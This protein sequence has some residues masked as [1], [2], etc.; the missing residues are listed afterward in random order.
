MYK[1]T[2]P[3]NQLDE[4]ETLNK[5][6]TCGLIASKTINEIVNKTVPGI[7]VK[8]LIVIGNSFVN[9]EMSKI[10]SDI[11][12]KGIAFPINISINSVAGNN[13]ITDI[14]IN[15]D[16][17]VKIDLSVH[18]D[19]YISSICFTTL[20]KS[21][22]YTVDDKKSK[23]LK[24]A[25]ECSREIFNHMKSG[26]TNKNIVNIMEKYTEKY[27]CNLPLTN[28]LV[29]ESPGLFSRQI[30]QYVLDG[31][32]DKCE[33]D[34][35]HKFI[36]CKDNPLYSFTLRETEF[37]EGEVYIIDIMMCSGTGKLVEN[38]TTTNIYRRDHEN[39]QML[40]LNTSKQVLNIFGLNTFPI[41]LDNIDSRTKLGLKECIEKRLV[42][43]Y[44][45][46]SEKEGEFIAR[47]KFT[48][49][50]TNDKP[51]LI[52]GRPAETELAKLK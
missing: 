2:S 49:L 16:D 10:Y 18:I 28:V 5:Y 17:L 3:I 30:S 14:I 11:K 19:G 31:Y 8:E 43:P 21:G 13:P 35:M 48:V 32:D 46:I 41:L 24:C 27:K 15:N 7:S 47:I 33:E 12:F 9:N 22:K 51:I 36:L 45:C 38:K 26:N 44:N 52:C 6:K 42:K 23:V 39:R 40:K 29:G 34:L 50:I 20:V 37:S 25:I 4:I 1:P